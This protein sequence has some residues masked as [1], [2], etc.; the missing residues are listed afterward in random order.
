MG[1]RS[2]SPRDDLASRLSEQKLSQEDSSGGVRPPA[3]SGLQAAPMA[4]RDQHLVKPRGSEEER[5]AEMKRRQEEEKRELEQ[6]EKTAAKQK[7][8]IG[9]TRSRRSSKESIDA[10]E[11][12]APDRKRRPSKMLDTQM[13]PWEEMFAGPGVPKNVVRSRRNSRDLSAKVMQLQYAKFTQGQGDEDARPA[14][15]TGAGLTGAMSAARQPGIGG[16]LPPASATPLTN[17]FGGDK[18]NLV[19]QAALAAKKQGEAKAELAAAGSAPPAGEGVKGKM[20]L[21]LKAAA[22]LVQRNRA[23]RDADVMLQRSFLKQ[24]RKTHLVY[25]AAL[26]TDARLWRDGKESISE[27]IVGILACLSSQRGLLL[28][29]LPKED[30]DEA[31]E[32]AG[33]GADA[34]A[35]ARLAGAVG[36]RRGSIQAALGAMGDSKASAITPEERSEINKQL[37]RITKAL[38]GVEKACEQAS[39]T[40]SDAQWRRV[41]DKAA[42]EEAERL[43]LALEGWTRE[44]RSELRQYD[45]L[46]A[47]SALNPNMAADMAGPSEAD[48]QKKANRANARRQSRNDVTVEA[49]AAGAAPA[50]QRMAKR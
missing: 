30:G 12:S 38:D 42:L 4:R 31:D 25:A 13:D 15:A 39:H 36:G 33:E 23:L 46:M 2:S 45:Q 26:T 24:V 49:A 11:S 34:A 40:A 16:A 18:M 50:A 1:D 7:A 9:Q 44:R 27:Q 5:A 17:P 47:V 6:E 32:G 48:K 35:A 3:S 19:A 37:E 10:E 43:A 41:Q 14:P 28:T 20:N 8:M 22:A 21:R 29:I